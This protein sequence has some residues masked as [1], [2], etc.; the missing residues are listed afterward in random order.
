MP[1]GDYMHDSEDR[2]LQPDEGPWILLGI[3]IF[4]VGVV[5]YSV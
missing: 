1:N 5:V 2:E 4:V 3:L